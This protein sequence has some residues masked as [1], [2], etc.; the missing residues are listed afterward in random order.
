[1]ESG[2]QPA[3]PR[4]LGSRHGIVTSCTKSPEI[5]AR[6]ARVCSESDQ[7]HGHARARALR[8]CF[9]HGEWGSTSVWTSHRHMRKSRAMPRAS[10]KRLSALAA[11]S[12]S[13]EAQRAS[14]HSI[15][16]PGAKRA[17]ERPAARAGAHAAAQPGPAAYGVPR[18]KQSTPTYTSKR[19]APPASAADCARC[20]AD[21]Q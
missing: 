17:S 3:G 2:R 6:S 12:A 9:Y 10:Q 7:P 15:D 11:A 21:H 18:A 14:P 1:M 16:Q 5:A 8:C 20:C 13:S 4:E 19:R